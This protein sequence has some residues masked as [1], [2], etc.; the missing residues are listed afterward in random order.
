[1]RSTLLRVTAGFL[2]LSSC[3]DRKAD[4]SRRFTLPGWEDLRIGQAAPRDVELTCES[5]TEIAECSPLRST[6]AIKELRVLRRPD[7]YGVV[8][9]MA[10]GVDAKLATQIAN[11]WG[12]PT[13]T[14]R[15]GH[16]W[17]VADATYAA[18]IE[19]QGTPAGATVF[20]TAEPDSDYV[21]RC[22]EL[23]QHGGHHPSPSSN[24]TVTPIEGAA[25]RGSEVQQPVKPSNVLPDQRG[26]HV[27]KECLENPLAKG[28]D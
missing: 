3:H 20:V 23:N 11:R 28:C 25:P 14:S 27:S 13:E 6:V 21:Q 24:V 18:F 1:M 8:R 9:V 15:E 19:G 5:A 2:V 22:V 7:K 4:D 16:L 12:P 10:I 26:V 17:C